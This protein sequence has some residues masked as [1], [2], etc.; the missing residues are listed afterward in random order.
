MTAT[1]CPAEGGP[2][3]SPVNPAVPSAA[4]QSQIGVETDGSGRRGLALSAVG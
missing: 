2:A 1:Q 3:K 4:E